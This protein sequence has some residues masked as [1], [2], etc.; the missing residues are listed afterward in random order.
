[1]LQ[2]ANDKLLLQHQIGHTMTKD[3]FY[4]NIVSLLF[5]LCPVTIIAFDAVLGALTTPKTVE[6]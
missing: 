6:C 2:K 3:H 5:L 4:S 1:M